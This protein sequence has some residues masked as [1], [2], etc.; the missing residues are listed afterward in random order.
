MIFSTFPKFLCGIFVTLLD[1]ID[2]VID[3]LQFILGKETHPIINGSPGSYQIGY[4]SNYP[5]EPH[6]AAASC[7]AFP[8]TCNWNNALSGTP[9][10]WVLYGALIG[11]PKDRVDTFEN[12]K[13]DY[14]TN[15]VALD[16]NCGFQGL[17]SGII[18]LEAGHSKL[19][20]TNF[21]IQNTCI[22]CII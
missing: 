3:Q 10:A 8:E 13:E 11:G 14:V 19:K 16:Y 4:G 1:S 22:K 15:E 21:I 6:H 12:D 7:G 18:Q 2:F 9:S 20:I 17:L 5:T